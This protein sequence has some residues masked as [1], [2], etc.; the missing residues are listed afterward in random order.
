VSLYGLHGNFQAQSGRGDALAEILLQ[1]AETLRANADCRV[2]MISRDADDSDR[3]WVTEVWT[4]EA[5]HDASLEDERVR[6]L[7][8][9]AMPL[10]EGMAG[11][12]EFRP[13][14]GKG[15]PNQ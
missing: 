11:S 5:T 4:D 10:I 2:Y 15:L 7:I 1:A 12:S 8:K 9:Q 13:V 6:A 3:V 14:G